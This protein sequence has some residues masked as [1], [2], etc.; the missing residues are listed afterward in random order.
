MCHENASMKTTHENA[1]IRLNLYI[2]IIELW[3]NENVSIQM[4]TKN[5]S[6][7]MPLQNSLMKMSHEN[8]SVK[9]FP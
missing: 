1:P 8:L 9:M 2:R 4:K 5:V 6:V 7:K 3:I